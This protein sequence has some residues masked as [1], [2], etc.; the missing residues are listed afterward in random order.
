[1]GS[2]QSYPGYVISPPPLTYK[3]QQ[4]NLQPPLLPNKPVMS[5]E[6]KYKLELLEYEKNR[7]DYSPHYE[8]CKQNPS[9]CKIVDKKQGEDTYQIVVKQFGKRKRK[10][11]KPHKKSKK[12]HKI[13]YKKSRQK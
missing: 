7:W 13:S 9:G 6:N 1:M 3:S 12:P 11:R 4:S 5:N 10:S 8:Y 2:S